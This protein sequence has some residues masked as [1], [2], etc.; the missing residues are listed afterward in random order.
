MRSVTLRL[1]ESLS[2]HISWRD[3]GENTANNVVVERVFT[4][5]ADPFASPPTANLLI[6]GGRDD[7]EME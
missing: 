6:R 2:V 7:G 4:L 5:T 1:Y 3:L